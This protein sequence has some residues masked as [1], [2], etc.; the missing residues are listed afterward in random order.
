MNWQKI[1]GMDRWESDNDQVDVGERRPGKWSVVS[2]YGKFSDKKFP[3]KKSSMK[4][5]KNYMQKTH[6]SRFTRLKI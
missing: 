1:S 6:S 3:D 2:I 5:A 4:W